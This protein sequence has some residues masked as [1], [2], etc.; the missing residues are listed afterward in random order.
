MDP[1]N[2]LPNPQDMSAQLGL[3]RGKSAWRWLKRLIWFLLLIGLTSGGLYW[4]LGQHKTAAKVSY[5][6]EPAAKNALEITVTA[7]GKVQPTTQVDVG[8][9]MS[10]II[11]NVLVSDNAFV[12]AGDILATLDTVRLVAE[13]ARSKALLTA[14]E[15]KLLD[16]RATLAQSQSALQ[17]QGKL[18]K[19]GL[20]TKD[21]FETA[22]A[23]QA[24][25]V[26]SVAA[27]EADIEVA[28]ADLAIQETDLQKSNVRS[29]I[30]GIVLKRAAE[31]GQTVAAS[32]QAPVLF[33]LA[34]DLTNIQIEVQVDEAD[35]GEVKIGQE[36]QFT[37]DAY[38]ERKFPARIETI[39][40]AP[41]TIDGV[42]TYKA[43]LSAANDDLALR[44]GM[45]ATARIVVQNIVDA[46]T[47]S[48]EALRFQPPRKVEAKG[49]SI[50]QLFLPRFP[51]G[52]RG[53]KPASAD[54]LRSIWIRENDEPK[55]LRV[56]IGAS[57]GKLTEI[58]SGDLKV[59]APVILSIKAAPK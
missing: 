35:I 20:A 13:L 34:E 18:Q 32:L 41:E 16:A 33:T 25:A 42:V 26:A 3:Q 6:T 48:N 44:P 19:G 40:Y 17:R 47:I 51:R 21:S 56:K 4:Y 5:E 15:A 50:S 2:T 39:A 46:L 59:D 8:S 38:R 24:R 53:K 49:F 27:A 7:T 43:T 37:V 30:N 36:A 29:P 23:G 45:T 52:E 12:K 11:R 10:G 14:A 55:E 28:K 58:I 57:D 1:M 54:G 9:E 31:P 22:T